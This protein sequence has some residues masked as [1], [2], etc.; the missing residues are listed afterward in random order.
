LRLGR[1]DLNANDVVDS[2]KLEHFPEKWIRFSD[3]ELLYHFESRAD[4]T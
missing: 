2:N 4:P 1:L 3:R